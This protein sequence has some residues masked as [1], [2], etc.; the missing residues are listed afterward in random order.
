MN[1]SD[2][3]PTEP[4]EYWF[5]LRPDLRVRFASQKVVPCVA[6]VSKGRAPTLHVSWTDADGCYRIVDLQKD[7]FDGAK[8][9]RREV[10][11]DPFQPKT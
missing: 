3:R 1:W 8:W 2:E 11:A 4:G 5:S 7:M 10:P 9:L 6:F